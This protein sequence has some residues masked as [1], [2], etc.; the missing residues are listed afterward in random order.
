METFQNIVQKVENDSTHHFLPACIFFFYPLEN[1]MK[2]FL[3][4][5]IIYKILWLMEKWPNL[6]ITKG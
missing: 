2:Y 4:K 5:S 6:I 3:Q 1:K